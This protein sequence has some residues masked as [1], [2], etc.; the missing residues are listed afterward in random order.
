MLKNDLDVFDYIYCGSSVFGKDKILKK[1][2]RTHNLNLDDIIYVGD[3][4][5]DVDMAKKV[6]IKM[7]AVTWGVSTHEA[8]KKAN[9]DFV[10][11]KPAELQGIVANF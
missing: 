4:V 10:V 7:I 6:G 9:A 3:E 11:D 2:A 5:R 1:M 8:L